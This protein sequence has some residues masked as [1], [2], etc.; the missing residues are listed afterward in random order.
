MELF[1]LSQRPDALAE[2]PAVMQIPVQWGD[3]DAYRHVNNVVSLR[4]FETARLAYF[5]AAGIRQLEDQGLAPILASASLDYHLQLLYP[6][7]IL[8]ASRIS[9]VGSK[10]LTME[11]AIYSKGQQEVVTRGTCI[12]V[13]YDYKLQESVV[14]SDEVRQLIETFESRTD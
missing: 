2:F 9:R 8:S 1:E 5:D 7:T 13:M 11:H 6:D 12:L 3:Q 4:W 10:S 14:A